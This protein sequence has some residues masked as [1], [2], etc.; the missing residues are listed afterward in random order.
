MTVQDFI[1]FLR[2]SK[3]N[4]IIHLP[5]QDLTL[6]E[7]EANLKRFDFLNSQMI[8]WNIHFSIKP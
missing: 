6:D 1:N 3:G 2:T 7:W 8:G 4:V 5:E